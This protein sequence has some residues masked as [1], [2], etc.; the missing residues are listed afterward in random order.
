MPDAVKKCTVLRQRY[1]HLNIEVSCTVL[2][3]QLPWALM[4]CD[5]C[6][7]LPIGYASADGYCS[8]S[9]CVL[10]VWLCL[11]IVSDKTCCSGTCLCAM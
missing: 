1:P 3:Q 10:I 5:E 7:W 4:L 6:H 11:T 8:S 2:V 9:D